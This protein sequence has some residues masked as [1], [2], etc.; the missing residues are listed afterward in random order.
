M[1]LATG[2]GAL[3]DV[4]KRVVVIGGGNTAVDSA[5]TALRLGSKVTILYRR[6]RKDMP[7]IVEET[8]AAEAEG[9]EFIELPHS[10]ECCG[11]G[12]VFS[13]EQAELSS[14][15]LQRK[16]EN[17]AASTAESVTAIA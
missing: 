3:P 11:Y 5:R 17:I 8:D 1:S 15:M 12:G 2:T 7:A 14:A 4:G 10:E 6:E 9:A 13:V 16:M